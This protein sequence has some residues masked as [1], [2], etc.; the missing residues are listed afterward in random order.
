MVLHTAAVV[1]HTNLAEGNPTPVLTTH[2]A[3]SV[4]VYPVF[5]TLVA[6]L[7]VVAARE[8]VVGSHWIS[9]L[10]IA[11]V[12]AHGFAP[13][14]VAFGFEGARLLFPLL[15][16]FA[17]WLAFAALLGRGRPRQAGSVRA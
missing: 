6:G 17:A 1:D 12:V 3:A 4:I 14:L 9:W 16:L 2:L 10:G 7:I 13:P 11:G 5:A 15:T 8:R